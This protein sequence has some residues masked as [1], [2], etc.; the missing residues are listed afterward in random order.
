[1]E[2]RLRLG[3]FVT[4]RNGAHFEEKWIE[5]S[6]FKD[7]D[8]R[9]KSIENIREEIERKKKQWAKKKPGASDGKKSKSRGDE[10]TVDEFYEQMEIYDL[11]KAMLVKEDKEIQNELERLDRERNLH[12]REI[13]RIAN[14]DA[15]RF[16][17]HP[18]L[19]DRYLLLN[20]L[21]KGGFSE[22]HKDFNV[23][24]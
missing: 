1:M 6:R 8:Q 24:P 7:L 4:Q 23:Y 15:S 21:G 22:V 19:S 3:Q 9:R 13:K 5:G 18:L 2:N 10:V 17:D 16:K 20:L 12:I 14:E 11:R